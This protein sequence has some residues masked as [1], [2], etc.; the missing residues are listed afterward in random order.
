MVKVWKFTQC[1]HLQILEYDS[2]WVELLTTMY[3]AEKID[4]EKTGGF[5]SYFL[6]LCPP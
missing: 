3:A 6:P 2:A 5:K 1:T 4:I